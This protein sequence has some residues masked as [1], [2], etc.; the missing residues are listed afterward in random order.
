MRLVISLIFA[1]F[2]CA[3]S[4]DADFSKLV[5]RY[6]DETA[7]HYGPG[8]ATHA[9]FHQF[10]TRLASGSRAEVQSE[11]AQLSKFR[12]E[13]EAFDPHGL[14]PGVSADREL[15]LSLI[16]G[17]LLTLESIRPWEKNPPQ[18]SQSSRS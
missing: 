17:Q 1:C 15:L 12:A 9:G 10:D 14:S 13:A 8:F 7:F 11:V 16:D 6:F 4:R 3:Q 18:L 5:D 2:C